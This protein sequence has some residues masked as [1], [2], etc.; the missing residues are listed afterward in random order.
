VGEVLAG[1]QA[2]G[3]DRINPAAAKSPRYET[4]THIAL[5]ECSNA[6]FGSDSI[7][8]GGGS[9]VYWAMHTGGRLK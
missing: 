6:W 8:G 9:D 5:L 1:R 4:F 3:D 2:F 7:V